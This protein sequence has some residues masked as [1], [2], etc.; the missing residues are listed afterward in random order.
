[1]EQPGKVSCPSLSSAFRVVVFQHN[2]HTRRVKT[3]ARL[4]IKSRYS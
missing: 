4:P 3:I 2:M 1:V